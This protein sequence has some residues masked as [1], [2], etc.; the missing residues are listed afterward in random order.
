M[1]THIDFI[2]L[3]WNFTKIIVKEL[4]FERIG[5]IREN[6]KKKKEEARNQMMNKFNLAESYTS[7]EGKSNN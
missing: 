3:S 4:F 2:L 5:K 7:N 6:Q 1:I